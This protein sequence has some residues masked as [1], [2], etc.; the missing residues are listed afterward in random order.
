MSNR[1][2]DDIMEGLGEAL[3][4][5]RGETPAGMRIHHVEIEAPDVVAIRRKTGLSQVRFAK[6]VNISAATLRQWEQGRR[7]PQ[8][9]AR[10]LLTA[11]DRD[12]VGVIKALNAA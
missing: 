1:V 12:P 3:D 9:P 2:F 8:G 6:A 10:A 7:R 4:H 11:I 5:A